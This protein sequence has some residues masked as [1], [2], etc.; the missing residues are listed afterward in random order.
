[1][2]QLASFPVDLYRPMTFSLD[3]ERLTMRLR[4]RD[5]AAW[6]LELLNEHEGG[7]AMTINEAEQRLV[8]QNETARVKGIGLLTIRR[9]A[10]G[11]AV[12]YCGLIIGR[13]T[14]DEPEIAYELLRRFRGHG[15][16]TEAA[17]AVTEA[18][19]ATGR[20]RLWATVR[21]WNAPSLR[22]L[23][24]TGFTRDHSLTDEKGEVVYMVRNTPSS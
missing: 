4:T 5:D 16:A 11:D 7:T 21:S 17:A 13:C 22:V 1:V 14:L 6:N 20:R 8:E 9:R 18:A 15:F 12:G 19:F 2:S 24:K 3:T 23:E 10:E